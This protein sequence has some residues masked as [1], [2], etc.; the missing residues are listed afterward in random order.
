[1]TAAVEASGSQLLVV[2]G[3]ASLLADIST[4]RILSGS[5]DLASMVA[6]DVIDIFARTKVLATGSLAT[7]VKQRFTGV[8][9][10]PI[11]APMMPVDSP[12]ETTF[13]IQ[14]ISGVARTIPWRVDSLG[15]VTVAASGTQVSTV[16]TEHVLATISAF[17]TLSL[18][19]DLSAMVAGDTVEL[20]LKTRTLSGGTTRE[21]LLASYTGE[22]S[23]PVVQSIPNISPYE[24]IV[25]LKHTAGV[26]KS[27]PWRV[28]SF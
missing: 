19:V 15:A 20:R 9:A 12:Y 27:F 23:V 4:N 25:T 10:Q 17:H 6:G 3:A 24:T 1:M 8:Q 11:L 26:T 13:S 7:I 5:F 14:Q 16:T 18:I 21:C 2:G 28:D 22:Q